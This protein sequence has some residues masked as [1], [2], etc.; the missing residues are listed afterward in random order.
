MVIMERSRSPVRPP[1]STREHG[2]LVGFP[3]WQRPMGSGAP[4]PPPRQYPSNFSWNQQG[5]NNGAPP[6]VPLPPGQPGLSQQSVGVSQPSVDLSQPCTTPLPSWRPPKALMSPSQRAVQGCGIAGLMQPFPPPLH[7]GDTALVGRAQPSMAKIPL[8]HQECL[9]ILLLEVLSPKRPPQVAKPFQAEILPYNM[10]K[11]G[12][13]TRSSMT[14]RTSMDCLF[15]ELL[16]AP[17][18]A[19]SRILRAVTLSLSLSASC[20]IKEAKTFGCAS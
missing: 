1:A 14:L 12:S 15:Q 11:I 3:V 18:G 7:H 10:G 13:L 9:H 17:A 4:V 8:H 19:S 5:P 2:P 6:E 20:F 16:A